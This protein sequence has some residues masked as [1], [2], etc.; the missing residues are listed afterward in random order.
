MP[1]EVSCGSAVRK[2]AQVTEPVSS[3]V[4][5]ARTVEQAGGEGDRRG[6][7]YWGAPQRCWAAW[8]VTPSRVPM[9]AQE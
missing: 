3:A 2:S 5:P 1:A 8:R 6:G 4:V 7:D 9:S